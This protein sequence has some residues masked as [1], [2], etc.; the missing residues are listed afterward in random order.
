MRK[1]ENPRVGK[2]E[3]V[4]EILYAKIVATLTVTIL[5]FSYPT[6]SRNV[7]LFLIAQFYLFFCGQL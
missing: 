7:A 5:Y 1:S 2:H 4:R 6:N 3:N